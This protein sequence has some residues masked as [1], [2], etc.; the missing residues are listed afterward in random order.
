MATDLTLRLTKGS[1]LTAQE[2]DNNFTAL[3]SSIFNSIIK[4]GNTG[5]RAAVWDNTHSYWEQTNHLQVNGGAIPNIKVGSGTFLSSPAADE[6]GLTCTAGNYN[7]DSNGDHM[8]YF[9]EARTGAPPMSLRLSDGALLL[10]SNIVSATAITS[11]GTLIGVLD[12]TSF[13]QVVAGTN[14]IAG[15]NVTALSD[16]RTKT[17]ISVIENPLDI[18]SAIDGIKYT[19]IKSGQRRT[20]VIAQEVIK[21]LPEVVMQTEDSDGGKLAVAYGNIAG[22][23]IESIKELKSQIEDIQEEIDKLQGQR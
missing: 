12:V 10:N 23:V 3:D 2:L 11:F 1:Q 15:G 21:V 20:G 18:I 16:I 5:G 7:V 4:P 9:D 14:V 19:D 6:F 13:A 8:W 22:V 17:D